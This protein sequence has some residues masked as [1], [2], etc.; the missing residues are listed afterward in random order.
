MTDLDFQNTTLAGVSA[1]EEKMEGFQTDTQ[2][3]LADPERLPKALK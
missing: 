3:L 1:L 2:K